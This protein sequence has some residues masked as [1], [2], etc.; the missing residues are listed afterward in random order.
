MIATDTSFSTALLETAPNRPPVSKFTSMN[1]LVYLGAGALLMVWPGA[2]QT[3]LFDAPFAGH[4]EGLFRALGMAVAVIGWLYLFG[5]RSGGRQFAAC[6]VLDRWILVPLVCIPLSI[7]GVFP[8]TF[9]A[10]AFL[11]IALAVGTWV[12]RKR[13]R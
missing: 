10:L 4:E 5:G 3:L 13:A 12:I 2:V 8:H 11:D 7:A 6:T 1:G 9:L